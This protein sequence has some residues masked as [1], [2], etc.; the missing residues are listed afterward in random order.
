[1][2]QFLLGESVVNLVIKLSVPLT[3]KVFFPMRYV[4]TSNLESKSY[5]TH[6]IPKD[7]PEQKL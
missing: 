4:L 2:V 3:R 5:F 7:G 1:M 6:P